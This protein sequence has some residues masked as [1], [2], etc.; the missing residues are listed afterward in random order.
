MAIV[1]EYGINLPQPPHQV[2]A[3]LDDF[4]KVPLWLKRCEGVAKEGP[5]PNKKGD[6]LRYA[7]REAGH[8]GVMDG[9]IIAHEPDRHLSYEYYD[10]MMSVAVDFRIDPREE[11]A[12]LTHRIEI[13]P[14][15]LMARMMSPFM[16]GMIPSQTVMA[17]ENIRGLL[18]KEGMGGQGNK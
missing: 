1:F 18:A 13:R 11:G 14:H 9:T 3:F 2:F 5:G 10:R 7:Y 16:R 8:H 6:K 15:S 17:M 4:K 12:R